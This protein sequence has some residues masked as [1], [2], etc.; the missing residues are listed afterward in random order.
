MVGPFIG[1]TI[2]PSEFSNVGIN[3]ELLVGWCVPGN[4]SSITLGGD[5]ESFN[6]EAGAVFGKVVMEMC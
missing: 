6:C 3:G 1:I 2:F 4:I 5:G